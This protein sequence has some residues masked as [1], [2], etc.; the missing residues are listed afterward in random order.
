[1]TLRRDT[2]TTRYTIDAE[3]I[4][5]RNDAEGRLRANTNRDCEDL[6]PRAT[7]NRPFQG[8]MQTAPSSSVSS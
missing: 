7:V 8:A 1:M 4:P 5:W 3:E 6:R 2:A